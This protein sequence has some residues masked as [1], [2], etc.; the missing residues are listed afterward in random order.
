MIEYPKKCLRGLKCQPYGQIVSDDGT[1]FFCCGEHDGTETEVAED[2]YRIC[3]KG[4]FDDRMSNYDKRDLT[5]E[6]SV[7]IQALAIIEC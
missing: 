7:I 2:I 1:S 6:A 5:H 4:E 3:F